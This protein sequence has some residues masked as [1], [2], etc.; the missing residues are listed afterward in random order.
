MFDK[1][2]EIPIGSDHGGFELKQ[3]LIKNLSKE[4]YLFNDLGT[5]SE[6]SVD[7]PDFIHP[8]AKSINDG[9]NI[10]GIIICGSGQGASMTANKYPNVRAALCWNLE[11]AELTRLHNNANIISL[12]GRFLDF[13]VATEMVKV[14]LDT[15]F[16]KGRHIDR[17][18]KIPVSL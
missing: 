11:Q 13:K 7:Y 18:N 4:G 9:L 16:E 6:D 14:F 8:V 3:F 1:S 5:Y 2:Q 10:F 17:I 15:D 12:P